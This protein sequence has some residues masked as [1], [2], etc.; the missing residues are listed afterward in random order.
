MS[1]S[2]AAEVVVL[3]GKIEFRGAINVSGAEV[4]S[5]AGIKRSGNGVAVDMELLKKVLDS[6]VMISSYTIDNEKGNLVI[7]VHEKYP[8]FMF[9]VVDKELSVPALVDDNMNV[10]VSGRFFSTDMPIIIVKRQLFDEGT[11]N[12]DIEELVNSLKQLRTVNR[13]FCSEIQEIEITDGKSLNVYLRNRRTH[14]IIYNSQAGFRRL[15]KTAAWLDSLS[16]YPDSVDLSEDAVL[17][18]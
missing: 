14:F 5:M 3:S 18:K 17:V 10:I 11:E 13:Q 15:D 1:F 6:N 9:L 12:R 7:N 4:V 8:L 2:A 16:R